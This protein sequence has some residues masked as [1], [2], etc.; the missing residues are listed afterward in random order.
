MQDL[1]YDDCKTM[2]LHRILE[3]QGYGALLAIDKNSEKICACSSNIQHFLGKAPDNILNH[4]WSEFLTSPMVMTLFQKNEEAEHTTSRV[5]TT[6]LNGQLVHISNHSVDTHCIVEIEPQVTIKTPFVFS[7]KIS[8]LKNLNGCNT[9]EKS[10]NLLMNTI[11]RLVDFD[12]IM[13]YKFLPD[14]HGEVIAEQN[15]PGVPGFLG[16]RFPAGDIPENARKVYTQNWQRSIADINLQNCE[17]LLHEDVQQLNL[18]WSQ[19]R[20]VHPV[21]LQYLRN[22]GAQASFSVSI[23]CKGKLW[24]LIACHHTTPKILSIPQRQICEELAR[25]TSLHMNSVM[26]ARLEQQR[27]FYRESMSEIRGAIHSQT[28]G[29]AA[30][31]R[32][33]AEIKALFRANGI[34]H[35]L[36]NRDYFSGQ[37]PKESSIRAL[38]RWTEQLNTNNILFTNTI[39]IELADHTDLVRDAS[40]LLFIPLNSADFIVL[41]RQEQ[42][43]NVNWAGKLEENTSVQ[44]E[45]PD[46]TPR[47]SFQSWAQQVRGH[48]EPWHMLDIETA[49]VFREE[50]IEH[51][52]KTHLEE[53][54]QTDPL[55]GL[56]NRMMFKHKLDDALHTS[57]ESDSQFAVYM[58]DLDNFKPVND[59]LGH[60]AGD[61]LLIKVGARLRSLLR[62]R[63]TVAR[64]GGDEFAIIQHQVRNHQD[65]DRV[66]ARMI[67]E[68][69]RPFTIGNN[70]IE[71]GASIG[72]AI[73]PTDAMSKAELI[74]AADIALYEMK[75]AGRDGFQHYHKSMRADK[76]YNE[77]SRNLLTNAF[78]ANEFQMVY[79]P[80]ID[81][82]SG[83]LTA[84]EAFSQWT[85]PHQGT[86]SA[87]EFIEQ[88]EQ[89]QLSSQ[90]AQW[91]LDTLF[92]QYHHWKQLNVASV[93]INF[94]I[95][96]QQFLNLD[97]VDMCKDLAEKHDIDTSWLRLNLDEQ[98]L[99]SE[100]RRTFSK[101]RTLADMGI[102]VN[103]NHFGQSLTSLRQLAEIKINSL[104]IDAS[105]LQEDVTKTIFDILL[106]MLKSISHAM[107]VPVVIAKL[108]QNE[109]VD[110]ARELGIQEIQGYAISKPLQAEE[111]TQRLLH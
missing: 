83:K 1:Q 33:I 107:D 32:K 106:A 65:I 46:L 38:K 108:E 93:P 34:W 81:T 26:E 88:I 99:F 87:S 18:T 42:I 35:H 100:P 22:I 25:I 110:R 68:L 15:K 49:Q 109:W 50:L 62:T 61:E 89:H 2:Q 16:L 56:A 74:E 12:R 4:D 39:P 51:L 5:I 17:V 72:I 13:L 105:L 44:D 78:D 77:N 90:W 14:W 80:I 79:Q 55:T 59:T 92:Q 60:A 8:F 54:A 43:E 29:Y 40:G 47:S 30:I 6:E 97:L 71:I 41:M 28:K 20:A 64:L 31:G 91:G 95:S 98:T 19:L 45:H 69:K 63:D 75:K 11:A 70:K 9:P 82:S 67:K 24:G 58:L 84:F 27:Y 66:A 94:I 21:H 10:A 53:I 23:I 7:N 86:L 48:A 76:Q 36:G 3:I 111:A 52:E 37:V 85:H 104:K 103:I 57:L 73:C 102:L 96:A 101:I